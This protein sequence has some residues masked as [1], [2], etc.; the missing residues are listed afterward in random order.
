[1]IHSPSRSYNEA[2]A[3]VGLLNQPHR[4]S[5]LGAPAMPG[6]LACPLTRAAAINRTQPTNTDPRLDIIGVSYQPPAWSAAWNFIASA[7]IFFAL[8][9]PLMIR[10]AEV[11]C[12]TVAAPLAGRCRASV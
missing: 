1:M 6:E 9:V 8:S 7:A 2:F 4:V 5:N 3:G 12:S 11:S 10:R